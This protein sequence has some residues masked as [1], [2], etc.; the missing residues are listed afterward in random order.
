MKVTIKN[1]NLDIDGYL[2][3]PDA[4]GVRPA[5]IVIQE[6]FGVNAHIRDI[7]DR[8]AQKG[9]IAIA[10]AIYQR[11]APNF[12][13]GYTPEDVKIGRVYKNQT[14]AEELLGD[15][16]AT[17]DYLYNLPPEIARVKQ[18]GVGCIGFCFGGH[19]AYLVATL[20]DIKATASFYGA[21]I[22]SWCPGD[23]VPTIE[24]TKDIKGT[25][26]AFFG[27]ADA[28]IPTTEID[29]IETELQKYKIPHQIFRYL[30]A[31]HGF[32]CDRRSSYREIAAIDAWNRVL[33]LF[34]QT[35]PLTCTKIS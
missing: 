26:F 13:V 5:V 25:L 18:N 20:S 12:E 1:G 7:V 24:Y 19:V 10:P 8:F 23:G 17:I 14:K 21:G 30:E 34:E 2:A 35:I 28:S 32:F 11:L 3:I 22:T 27:L 16:Q 15:I 6:I 31:E 33:D 9:Y 4:E 29:R